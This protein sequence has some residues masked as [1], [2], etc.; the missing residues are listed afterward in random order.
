MSTKSKLTARSPY[1]IV[2]DDFRNGF[3]T[4]GPDARWSYVTVGSYVANDGVI[5]TSQH[6]LQVVSSGRKHDTGQPAFVHT[7]AH[8][9]DNGH[10]LPGTLDHVKWLAF[11]NHT[12]ST[13]SRAST[14]TSTTNYR[15]SH[16]YRLESTEPMA[17]RSV[18]MWPTPTRTF[19]LPR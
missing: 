19:A 2:W 18:T 5:T 9:E 13:G 6:G 15:V 17:I 11:T 10:G 14:P 4:S 1:R 3:S 12:A 16:G 8:E 7:V